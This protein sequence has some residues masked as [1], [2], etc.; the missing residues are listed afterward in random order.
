MCYER[1]DT[2]NFGVTPSGKHLGGEVFLTKTALKRGLTAVD[3]P[4]CSAERP[5]RSASWTRV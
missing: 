3:M 1:N 2:C 4:V 5:L